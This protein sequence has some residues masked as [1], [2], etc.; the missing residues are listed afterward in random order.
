[1]ETNTA[2]IIK[3]EFKKCEII[4]IDSMKVFDQI[5]KVIPTE[6][7]GTNSDNME[8]SLVDILRQRKY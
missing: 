2:E 5:P 6:E 3:A 4:P 1:M 7:T 8:N